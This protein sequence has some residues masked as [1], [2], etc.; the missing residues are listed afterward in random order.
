ML[1]IYGKVAI[2]LFILI[3]IPTVIFGIYYGKVRNNTGKMIGILAIG[4]IPL[5][6]LFVLIVQ[7]SSDKNTNEINSKIKSLGG[8]VTSAEEVPPQNTP[9]LP[10]KNKTFGSYFKITYSIKGKEFLA[11]FRSDYAMVQIPKPLEQ[12]KWILVK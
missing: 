5:I 11:W 1:P 9:F 6:I 8:I 12:D 7:A 4:I 10:D 3:I 2:I